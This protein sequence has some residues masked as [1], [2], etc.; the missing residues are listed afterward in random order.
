MNKEDVT[1][2]GQKILAVEQAR[3]L[4]RQLI[5]QDWDKNTDLAD[6]IQL[7]NAAFDSVMNTLAERVTGGETEE[8]LRRIVISAFREWEVAQEKK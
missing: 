1:L 5:I 8:T 2:K 4:A 3:G 7:K 6:E